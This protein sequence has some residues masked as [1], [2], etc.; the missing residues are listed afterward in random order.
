MRIV[1]M[2]R[3][4]MRTGEAFLVAYGRTL[5]TTGLA[6]AFTLSIGGNAYSQDRIPDPLRA[7]TAN[8]SWEF[9]SPFEPPQLAK[10]GKVTHY[11]TGFDGDH[12]LDAATVAERAFA[13]YTL[14]TVHIQF[15][16]GAE[17]SIALTAP[18][19]GLQP[20]VRDMSGDSVPNDLVFT[21]TLFRSPLFVLLNDGHNHLIVAISPG[22]FALGEHGL[23]GQ[24]QL[25][26]AAALVASRFKAGGLRNGEGLFSPQMQESLLF[27]VAQRVAIRSDSA[28]SSG[29]APPPLVPKIS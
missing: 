12:S 21:S 25:P 3:N 5:W 11:S 4:S 16:S 20:E 14:Y 17:Q 15:A 24:H 2:R 27:P 6:L 7:H 8:N 1:M 10:H 23:S 19:G 18:P 29:R 26:R 22:S 9:S 13:R 28:S